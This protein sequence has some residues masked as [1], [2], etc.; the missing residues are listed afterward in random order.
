MV[1][2]EI[3]SDDQV[4]DELKKLGGRT[5]ALALCNALVTAGHP[6]PE[7]QIAIQRAAERQR[8]LV[9]PDWA[10]SLPPVGVLAA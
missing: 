8:I 6:R 2:V 7:S 5:T 10:L 3:P 4:V 1:Y 9:G